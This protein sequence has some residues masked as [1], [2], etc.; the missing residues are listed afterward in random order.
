MVGTRVLPRLKLFQGV[1]RKRHAIRLRARALLC[2]FAMRGKLQNHCFNPCCKLRR[3]VRGILFGPGGLIGEMREA[4]T[5]SVERFPRRVS[6]RAPFN[7]QHALVQLRHA[8]TDPAEGLRTIT[9]QDV[10]LGSCPSHCARALRVAALDLL[11]TAHEF[12]H[13]IFDV[14]PDILGFLLRRRCACAHLD[15]VSVGAAL[16]GHAVHAGFPT[17][18]LLAVNSGDAAQNAAGQPFAY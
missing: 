17:G 13:L 18:V 3:P 7:V 15:A 12:V 10:D 14:S 6:L 16:L 11:D 2:I 9:Q 1:F 5:Q 8:R 4:L